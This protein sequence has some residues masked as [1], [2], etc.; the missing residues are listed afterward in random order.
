M[1]DRQGRSLRERQVRAF[2]YSWRAPSDLCRGVGGINRSGQPFLFAIVSRAIPKPRPSNAGRTM[3]ADDLPV[4]VLAD[5][6]ENEQVLGNDGVA[7]HTHH[8]GDVGDAPRTVT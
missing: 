2:A 7:F 5:Q 4:G 6:V 8:L 1:P 3:T